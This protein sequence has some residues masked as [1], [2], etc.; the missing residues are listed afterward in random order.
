M[1][2]KIGFLDDMKNIIFDPKRVP[3][4]LNIF[5]TESQ[6]KLVGFEEQDF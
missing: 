6:W 3:D 2:K 4:D 1:S 5:T